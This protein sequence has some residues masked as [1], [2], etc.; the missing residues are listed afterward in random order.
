M[1]MNKIILLDGGEVEIDDQDR[2]LS[3]YPWTRQKNHEGN[4]N[5]QRVYRWVG[6]STKIF[7]ARQIINAP[8]DYK[9]VHKDDNV[10]NCQRLN[11]FLAKNARARGN[12]K[13]TLKDKRTRVWRLAQLNMLDL[14]VPFQKETT[15][16]TDNVKVE[17]YL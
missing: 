6:K 4:Y 3:F 17:N 14:T 15:T 13:Y 16:A 11:L 8:K 10:L 9:V 2:G 12:H 5:G 1:I 7:L